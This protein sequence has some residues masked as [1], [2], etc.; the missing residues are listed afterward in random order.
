V[1]Y[2]WPQLTNRA[3]ASNISYWVRRDPNSE[4]I[5]SELQELDAVPRRGNG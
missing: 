5:V 2:L 1:R 3:P 4:P